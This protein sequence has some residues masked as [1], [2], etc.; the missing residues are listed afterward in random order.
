MKP[1]TRCRIGRACCPLLFI[2]LLSGCFRAERNDDGLPPPP[3]VQID[4]AKI[5]T[6][7]CPDVVEISF[8]NRSDDAVRTATINSEGD[9]DLGT[10]GKMRI[11]GMTAAEAQQTIA[12]QAGLPV[13]DVQVG[14]ARYKSRKLFLFGDAAGAAR[15]VSYHGPETVVDVLRRTGALTPDSAWNEI[16][17]VRSHL[18]DGAPSEVLRIDLE[19]IL[20]RDDNRTNVRVQ[21]LDE[22]YIGEKPSA[23][24]RRSVPTF[25]R[26]LYD[27][28]ID[29]LPER[30]EQ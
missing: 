20:K 22:I 28:I 11:E 8:L 26:P 23:H 3:P 2:A 18:A 19:A 17:L 14:V 5:Y 25:L 15:I 21:P 12:E 30:R 1:G 16:H 7:A 29:L 10:L 6:V 27:A 13:E 4:P 9:I 24:I